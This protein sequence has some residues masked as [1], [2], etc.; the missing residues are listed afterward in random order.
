MTMGGKKY[1]AELELDFPFKHTCWNLCK[2]P[3]SLDF[4]E[5]SGTQN[6]WKSW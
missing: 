5:H 1:F 4:A 3:V 2:N 6:C